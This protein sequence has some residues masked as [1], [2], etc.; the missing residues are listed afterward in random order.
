MSPHSVVLSVHIPKCA[1]TSFRRVLENIY[2]PRLWINNGIVFSR[3]QGAEGGRIPQGTAAIH[4]HYLADAFDDVLPDRV[5]ITWVR[6]PVE[7]VSSNYYY[8]LANPE[9][10]AYD[11]CCHQL[12][13]RKLSLTAYAELDWMRN[14][15]TRY[16]AAKPLTAFA[17]VGV[18]EHFGDSLRMMGGRLGWP[19]V[20]LPPRENVNPSRHSER[21][22]ISAAERAYIAGIN[23]RDL[24]WYE[25][26]VAAL[27][28]AV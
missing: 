27:A 13:A 17:A 1:G 22:E 23:D 24:A 21:Y 8:H 28:V 19:S 11:D 14:L 3:D 9:I 16:L 20:S 7:R 15:A 10:G 25:E 6:H 26:A 4:G 5:L 2:G 12:H 18:A